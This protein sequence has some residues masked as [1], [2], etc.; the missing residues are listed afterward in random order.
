[1]TENLGQTHD[2]HHAG[3]NDIA[4][5]S[6]WPNRRQLVGIADEAFAR[7]L[8]YLKERR[9]FDRVIGEFQG[10][11]HR[12]AMLYC[13]IELARA[14]VAKAL[15]AFDADPAKAATAVSI[16]TRLSHVWQRRSISIIRRT[17]KSGIASIRWSMKD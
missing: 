12:A 7:T 2:R 5:H 3:S 9:Q 13:D 14:A 17:P 4:K 6:A 11:Q 8:A 16:A 1:M 15:D 10:L